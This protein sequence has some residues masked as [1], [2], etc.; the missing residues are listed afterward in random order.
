MTKMNF[1]KQFSQ[2]VVD[3]VVYVPDK[4][5]QIE[6]ENLDHI[7]EVAAFGGTVA[8]AAVV[9]AKVAPQISADPVV[10]ETPTENLAADPILKKGDA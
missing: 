6:V 7:S 4:N 2:I 3:G 10:V 8:T 5:G 1:P 9:K